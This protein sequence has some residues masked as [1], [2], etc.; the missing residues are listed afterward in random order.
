MER[1]GDDTYAPHLISGLK[2][3]REKGSLCDVTIIIDKERFKAH[4]AVLSATSTYFN[5]MFTSGFQES[6]NSEVKIGEGS[7]ETFKQIL[8]FAY[9]GYFHVS[10]ETICNVLQMMSYMDFHHAIRLCVDYVHKV[11]EALQLEDVFELYCFTA[12]HS[13]LEQ[14]ASTL[15][16]ILVENFTDFAETEC[17]LDHA[18]KDFL[19]VC[20]SSQEIENDNLEEEEVSVFHCNIYTFTFQAQVPGALNCFFLGKDVLRKAQKRGSKKHIFVCESKI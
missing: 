3:L 18:S 20:L 10:P 4:K 16:D 19:E 1:V 9:T 12:C 6:N 14:L 5:S 11:K 7:A 13:D 2:N 17:F 8:D 15:L